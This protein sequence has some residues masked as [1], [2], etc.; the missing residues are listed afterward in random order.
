MFDIIQNLFLMIELI[1][2]LKFGTEL[3]DYKSTTIPG[4]CANTACC[5]GSSGGCGCGSHCSVAAA[6]SSDGKAVGSA[7]PAFCS[8]GFLRSGAGPLQSVFV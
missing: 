4:S 5:P 2:Q 7:L 6:R 1:Q 8:P 3:P